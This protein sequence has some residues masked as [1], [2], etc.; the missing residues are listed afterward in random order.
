MLRCF[1]ICVSV[2]LDSAMCVMVLCAV[3]L[4][5]CYIV[6]L[7]LCYF[8]VLAVGG[9]VLLWTSS[10]LHLSSR[11]MCEQPVPP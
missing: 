5:L 1:A 8:C 6:V 11:T 7:Y 4:C 10:T 2:V 3:S 9:W